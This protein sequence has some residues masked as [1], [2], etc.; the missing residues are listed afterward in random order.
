MPMPMPMTRASEQTM[1][2]DPSLFFNGAR[3]ANLYRL[4]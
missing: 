1:A 3:R 2:C 4:D